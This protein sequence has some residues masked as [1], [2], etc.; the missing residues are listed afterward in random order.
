MYWRDQ[1]KRRATKTKNV[2]DW[3]NFKRQKNFVNKEVKRVKKSF[4]R[5]EIER[6]RDDFKGGTWRVLNNL[7]NEIKISSSESVTNPK[8]I[9]DTLNQHFIEIGQ[10]FA[11][12]IPDPPKGKSFESFM[13][14]SISKFKLQKV[15]ESKALKLLLA[16]DSAKATGYDK[17][18]NKL[19]KIA[20][21]H[22]CQS[23]TSLTNI[24]PHE[25]GIAN[26]STLFKTGDHTDKDNYRP[27]LV[28]HTVTRIF[29]RIIYEQLYTYL[30]ENELINLQ[31]SGFRSLQST[32]T[33]L[34]DRTNEW[35][36]NIDRKMVNGVIL[37]DLKK[38]FDT[39]NHSI[40]LKKLEY[41][42]FDCSSIAFFSSYL[43][44]RLQQCNVNGFSSE[45]GSISYGVPQGTILGSLLFLIYIND[46]PNCLQHCTA[47]LYADNSSLNTSG[48]QLNVIEPLMNADLKHVSSWLIANKLT[49]NV[50][51]TVYMVVGSRQRLATLEGDLKLQIDGTSLKRVQVTKCLGV[52][53]D[54]NLT[55][56]K[57]VNTYPS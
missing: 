30:I 12:E 23:L 50:I 42:G 31:Q 16:A 5:T 3:E 53:M 6:N 8:D 17:I 41:F 56:E 4:Y 47:R 26:V 55:W 34:L 20:A 52:Q 40:L 46:L 44:N 45:L 51:K 13:K 37:L 27:I 19:L 9:A 38:A 36:Y 10:K 39:V 25:F 14:R 54:K 21:L 32:V 18:P 1:L 48:T 49:L 2:D 24:F 11:S 33:A 35:C 15:E 7:M 28:I 57:H 22:I 29:E 43:S